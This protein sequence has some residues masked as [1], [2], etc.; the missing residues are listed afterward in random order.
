MDPIWNQIEQYELI[1][2]RLCLELMNREVDEVQLHAIIFEVVNNHESVDR[3]I[4]QCKKVY[5]RTI[6][7]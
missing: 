3:I 1:V 7:G 4:A 6:S 5:T 2:G